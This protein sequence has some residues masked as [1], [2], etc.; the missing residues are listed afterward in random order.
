MNKFKKKPFNV[1][2]KM[3]IADLRKALSS[4]IHPNETSNNHTKL[5]A[6]LVVIYGD[7]PKILMTKKSDW[8]KEHAGEISFPGGKLDKRDEDLLATA[9]RETK[10][11][12]NLKI[13]REQVTGQLKPVTTLNSGFSI[14][15]FVAVLDK[16]PNVQE[17]L[18]VDSILHIPILPFLQTFAPDND[19]QHRS[20][21]EMYTLTFKEHL[22]WGASARILKQILD[23]MKKNNLFN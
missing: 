10:E 22:V 7:V 4:E 12:I 6:V 11:E 1:K 17:N 23:I 19:P 8:L 16:L 2:N 5:A 3:K 18:E 15:P 20:I 21:Q 14:T 9:L 13:S